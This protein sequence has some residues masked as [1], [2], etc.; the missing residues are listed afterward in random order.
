M[1]HECPGAWPFPSAPTQRLFLSL[2]TREVLIGGLPAGERDLTGV[3]IR[4]Q[5]VLVLAGSVHPVH[6]PPS[7]DEALG[8]DY[9]QGVGMGVLRHPHGPRTSLLPKSQLPDS[10][11]RDIG[12][13]G[14]LFRGALLFLVLLLRLY[15]GALCWR[16]SLPQ[17]DIHF[18]P[19]LLK[20]GGLGGRRSVLLV[21]GS[22]R[23]IGNTDAS[24]STRRG[25]ERNA[26]ASSSTSGGEERNGDASSSTSGSEDQ[27]DN[28]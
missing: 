12:L 26:D 22:R 4:R 25:E 8:P 6:V 27:N 13:P 23:K 5:Q 1:R 18:F 9:T 21:A 24:T 28:A 11:G 14:S 10:L 17:G 7:V 3:V 20:A 16:Q 2:A 15:F 19:K